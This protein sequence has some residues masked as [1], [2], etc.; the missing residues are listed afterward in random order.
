M[1]IKVKA[2]KVRQVARYD[3]NIGEGR[4]GKKLKEGDSLLLSILDLGLSEKLSRPMTQA[5]DNE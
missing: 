2:R 3:S 1:G 5:E 4:G